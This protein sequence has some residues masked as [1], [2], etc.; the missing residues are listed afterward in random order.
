[1][2][3]TEWFIDAALSSDVLV[4]CPRDDEGEIIT[5]ISLI[6]DYP[7]SG[8]IVGVFHPDGDEAVQ[9]WIDR[10]QDRIAVITGAQP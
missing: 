4:L 1:M 7:P 9:D 3:Y 8:A 10:N 6:A 5:G 2:P